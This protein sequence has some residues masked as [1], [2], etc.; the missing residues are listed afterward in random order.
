MKCSNT[1]VLGR[2]L[3]EHIMIHDQATLGMALAVTVE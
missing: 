3:Y 2:T 1:E